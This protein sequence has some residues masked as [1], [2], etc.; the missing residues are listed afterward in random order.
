MQR[1]HAVIRVKV[2]RLV[3]QYRPLVTWLLSSGLN[4]IIY[5]YIIKDFIYQ[6]LSKG[7]SYG[8][9]IYQ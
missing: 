6:T 4:H 7:T 9:H 3:F 5:S 1:Q 8:A 2:Q